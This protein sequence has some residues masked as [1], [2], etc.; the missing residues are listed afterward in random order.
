MGLLRNGTFAQNFFAQQD[1]CSTGLWVNGFLLSS[2]FAH[3]RQVVWLAPNG[4]SLGV[5]L[6]A[7][8]TFHAPPST[9]LHPPPN[10]APLPKPKTKANHPVTCL[11]NA[12]SPNNNGK[13]IKDEQRGDPAC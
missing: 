11:F 8:Q 5:R 3:C 10:K 13:T 4:T 1:V 6:L 7:R 2:L 12:K 9:P